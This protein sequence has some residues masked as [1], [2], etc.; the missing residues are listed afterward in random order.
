MCREHK[1]VQKH[2]PILTSLPRM[3][4]ASKHAGICINLGSWSRDIV[5]LSGLCVYFTE[6]G[7]KTPEIFAPKPLKRFEE[8]NTKPWVF[9]LYLIQNFLFANQC[10]KDS[11][12]APNECRAVVGWKVEVK[13]R[14]EKFPPMLLYP[15]KIPQKYT[16]SE[17]GYPCSRASD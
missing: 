12:N 16:K 7:A 13:T 17:P 3:R 2:G 8:P 5:L 14:K 11:Q 1:K 6:L 4:T 15:P 9:L 10:K